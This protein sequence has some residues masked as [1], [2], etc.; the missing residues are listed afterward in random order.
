MAS[1]FWFFM[2]DARLCRSRIDPGQ[3][4]GDIVGEINGYTYLD[5]EGRYEAGEWEKEWISFGWQ[6]LGWERF[7]EVFEVGAANS[8]ETTD[9]DCFEVAALGQ[10]LDRAQGTPQ[11][12][13][14]VL[15]TER[16]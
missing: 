9:A 12:A 11:L 3:I 2:V 16:R 8:N 5:K 13:R 10:L 7:K 4:V 15:K 6:G 14:D 1:M